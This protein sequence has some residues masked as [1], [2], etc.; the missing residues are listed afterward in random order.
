MSLALLSTPVNLRQS[1]R[2]G[3]VIGPLLGTDCPQTRPLV[4]LP[5]AGW[6]GALS[7]DP[8]LPEKPGLVEQ[9]EREPHF[10]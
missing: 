2:S 3:A 8:A 10:C 9:K 4:V 1:Y 5:G 6:V 7:Q